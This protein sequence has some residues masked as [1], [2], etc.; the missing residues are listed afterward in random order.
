MARQVEIGAGA[1]GELVAVQRDLVVDPEK[2]IV[3]EVEKTLI[4]KE[5]GEGNV[6]VLEQT[7]IQAI[8]VDEV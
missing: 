4:A 2:R 3:A 8:A 5:D 6:H 1:D 7:R